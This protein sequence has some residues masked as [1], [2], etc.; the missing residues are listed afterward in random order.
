MKYLALLALPFA[1][2]TAAAG[3]SVIDRAD[4]LSSPVIYAGEWEHF[5]GGGVAILD[6]NAD[7]KPDLFVAGGT[8][9]ASLL[10]NR[11][12]ARGPVRFNDGGMEPITG[13][14]GAY[15]LD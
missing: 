14:T 8:N 6:C 1:A 9:P 15:P 7:L 2:Q 3:P 11:S 10:V 4:D 12:D 13:V 5:V